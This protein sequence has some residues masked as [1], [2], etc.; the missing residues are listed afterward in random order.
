MTNG[1]REEESRPRSI[2]DNIDVLGKIGLKIENNNE[3]V[4]DMYVHYIFEKYQ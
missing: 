2:I 4:C 3:W 1:D